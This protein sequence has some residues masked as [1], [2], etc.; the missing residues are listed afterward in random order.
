[1]KRLIG[2]FPLVTLLL[3]GCGVPPEQGQGQVSRYPSGLLGRYGAGSVLPPGEQF[4]STQFA[5]LPDGVRWE[6]EEKFADSTHTHSLYRLK[7]RG[8]G[9]LDHWLKVHE[10]LGGGVEWASSSWEVP[11]SPPAL[12]DFAERAESVRGIVLRG[13]QQGRSGVTSDVR[14]EPTLFVRKDGKAVAAFHS[15]IRVPERGLVRDAVLDAATGD[16]LQ[17][18][19][20]VYWATTTR[21]APV[22][23]VSPPAEPPG[24]GAQTGTLDT[25]TLI[26]LTLASPLVLASEFF[27]VMRAQTTS[28]TINLFD[29]SPE[30]PTAYSSQVGF[31]NDP[32][33]YAQTCASSPCPN[34]EFDGLNVYYHLAKYRR[35]VTDN[36]AALGSTKVFPYDPL[37]VVVNFPYIETSEGII[38]QN[39]AAYIKPCVE[40][41]KDACLVFLRPGNTS[42]A[43]CG[44]S[45]TLFGLAREGAVAV[46]EYQHYLTDTITGLTASTAG[47][48]VGDALHEGYSDYF[49]LSHISDDSGQNI[50]RILRYA[51]QNCLASSRDLGTLVEFPTDPATAVKAHEG[52]LTWASG[53]WRLRTEL[54]TQ[55]ADLLALKSQFFLPTNAGY[56]DAVEAV[57]KADQSLNAGANVTRIREIFYTTLKF[58]GNVS[59]FRDTTTLVAEVGFRSCAGPTN[60]RGGAPGPAGA[61]LALVAWVA[62]LLVLGRAA[63]RRFGGE[64]A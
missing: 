47:T 16:L 48:N 57:V 9:V 30:P 8:V 55:K 18:R 7:Y 14:L 4:V 50:T 22:Y 61:L 27:K 29:V 28:S 56:I 40:L 6:L 17:E 12:P 36:L 23:L 62:V 64:R 49:A 15:S 19:R 54:G 43:K 1:M 58:I 59:G 34:Q 21:T 44:G 63:A 2:I 53:L 51:Y 5:A 33:S 31:S 41:S 52:G 11:F 24:S 10:R 39:N 46:H 32:A 25:G 37:T 20:A 45:A 38:S 42:S 26:D 13:L 35:R 60:S 3:V